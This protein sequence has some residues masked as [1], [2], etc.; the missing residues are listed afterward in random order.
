[1]IA[2]LS[3]RLTEPLL[4]VRDLPYCGA[5][6]DGGIYKVDWYFDEAS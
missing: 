2:T 6:E 5:T 4:E 1:M 3:Y